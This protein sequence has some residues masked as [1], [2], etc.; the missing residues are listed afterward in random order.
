MQQLTRRVMLT[1]P[2]AIAGG[3]VVRRSKASSPFYVRLT[4]PSFVS[5]TQTS[6][7]LSVTGGTPTA[8]DVALGGVGGAGCGVVV[9]WLTQADFLAS[10]GDISNPGTFP[11][12]LACSATDPTPLA[13]G[14]TESLTIGSATGLNGCNVIGLDCGTSY[15][16]SLQAAGCNG[17]EISDR[18]LVAATTQACVA[19]C[20]FT[21]GYWKTHPA[22]WPTG[23]LPML[24]GSI[25][26]NQQQLL[27]IFNT[28]PKG[29]GLITLAHQLIA[30]KLNLATGGGCSAAQTAVSQAD[31]LIGSLNVLGGGFLAPSTT[32]SLVT[33]LDT[34]NQG[35]L[36]GCPSHCA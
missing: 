1:F 10:G 36:P 20:T 5:A 9:R 24:L 17:I 13:A 32:G 7:T 16:F 26:Y 11:V 23:A 18:V 15:V 34:Y 2:I 22:V 14:A 25:S 27:T 35:L 21:L 8:S 31:A 30:A 12:A 28:P 29:N 4:N 19:G 6:V 33:Q 3:L